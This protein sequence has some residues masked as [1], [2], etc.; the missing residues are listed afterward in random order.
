MSNSDEAV[1]AEEVTPEPESR[2]ESESELEPGIWS[3]A[4]AAVA[5]AAAGGRTG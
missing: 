2:S 4:R 1:P 3:D 5:E